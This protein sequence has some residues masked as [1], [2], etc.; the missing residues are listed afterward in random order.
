MEKLFTY[1]TLRNPATQRRLLGRT[2]GEGEPDTLR[3]Y[4]LAKLTGIHEVYSILQPHPGSAVEGLLFEVSAEELARL[5][6]YEGDAYQRVSV[7]LMSKTRA[8]AYMEN[9]KSSFRVHIEP[10][11][12]V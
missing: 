3:G 8:W 1:G 6:A 2:L 4:R 12:P 7:R 9:P 5:D 10:P 11:A